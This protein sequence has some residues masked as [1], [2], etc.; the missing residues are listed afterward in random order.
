MVFFNKEEIA[1]DVIKEFGY[2]FKESLEEMR[3]RNTHAATCQDS[4]PK[5]IRSFMAGENY[6]DVIRN[7]ISLGGDTDTLAAIAGAMAEAFYGIPEELKDKCRA[8]VEADMLK[9][10]KDFDRLL[11]R[12]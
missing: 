10:L 2:D 6:E 3:N 1:D 5:A 12:G 11:E 7:A 8:R 9:V 4:L